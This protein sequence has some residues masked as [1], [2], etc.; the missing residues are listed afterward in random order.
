MFISV[1]NSFPFRVIR[2]WN[3]LPGGHRRL[4]A[5]CPKHLNMG[6]RA[7][8]CLIENVCFIIVNVRFLLP[9]YL[10]MFSSFE[11]S[12][13]CFE[14]KISRKN[15]AF[16]GNFVKLYNSFQSRSIG[17][18]GRDKNV[19]VQYKWK[20][21]ATNQIPPPHPIQYMGS[22]NSIFNILVGFASTREKESW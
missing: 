10:S 3:K 7:S 4:V 8:L 2:V 16:T 22:E 21:T 18:E 12:L 20:I 19:G 6:K 11:C 14:M 1:Y 5:S 9:F 17:K 15:K 13:F